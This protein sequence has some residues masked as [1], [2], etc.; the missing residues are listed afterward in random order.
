[1]LPVSDENFFYRNVL[2]CWFLF[3]LPLL[4]CAGFNPLLKKKCK[5]ALFGQYVV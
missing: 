1:M 4:S 3:G 5:V 2:V